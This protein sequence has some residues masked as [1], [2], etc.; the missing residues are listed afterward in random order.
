MPQSTPEAEKGNSQLNAEE[1]AAAL[2][3]ANLAKVREAK[4]RDDTTNEPALPNF[5][6]GPGLPRPLAFSFYEK[7]VRYPGYLLCSYDVSENHYDATNEPEWLESALLQVRGRGRA[8]FPTVSWIAVAICNRAEHK[9]VSTFEQSFKSAAVFSASDVF[10]FEVD[11]QMISSDAKM[12]RHPFKY[13]PEGETK[14]RWLIV[15]RHAAT[16]CGTAGSLHSP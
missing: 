5:V 16:N 13:E 9:G 11:L 7:D 2:N 3:R 4:L 10:N 15:E 6:C 8:A 1:R 14:Q 12:D